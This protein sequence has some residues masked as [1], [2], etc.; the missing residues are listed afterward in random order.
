MRMQTFLSTEK[1]IF[2]IIGKQINFAA[3][4]VLCFLA[5]ER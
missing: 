5:A 4:T 2:E 3:T 1:S